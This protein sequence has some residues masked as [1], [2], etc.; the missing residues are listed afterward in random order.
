MQQQQQ[1]NYDILEIII[2]IGNSQMTFNYGM[3]HIPQD[4]EKPF[5]QTPNEKNMPFLERFRPYSTSTL[6]VLS[7]SKVVEFFFDRTTFQRPI[8]YE[9]AN[10]IDPNDDSILRQNVYLTLF[11][12]FPTGFPTTRNIQFSCDIIS[13]SRSYQGVGSGFYGFD[14]Y[15]NSLLSIPLLTQREQDISKNKKQNKP[16]GEPKPEETKIKVNPLINMFRPTDKRFSYIKN[17]STIYTISQVVWRNDIYNHPLYA[18]FLN[19]VYNY[20]IRFQNLI[21]EKLIEKNKEESGQ[22]FYNQLL[23]IRTQLKT[24]EAEKNTPNARGNTSGTK[25]NINKSFPKLS[26][27]FSYFGISLDDTAQQLKW[28]DEAVQKKVKDNEDNI[29]ELYARDINNELSSLY[30]LMNRVNSGGEKEKE[31][32]NQYY[33]NY[34]LTLDLE[35]AST[36]YKMVPW[37]NKNNYY[38]EAMKKGNFKFINDMKENYE[39]LKSSLKGLSTN[40][41]LNK[42]LIDYYYGDNNKLGKCAIF[43]RNK[44]FHDRRLDIKKDKLENIINEANKFNTDVKEI[45]TGIRGDYSEEGTQSSTSTTV[46]NVYTIYLSMNV[47]DQELNNETAYLYKCFLLNNELGRRMENLFTT[48]SNKKS[49]ELIESEI[50]HVP[51]IGNKKLSE[52]AEEKK[53]EDEKADAAEKISE[54]TTPQKAGK[55]TK[56]RRK[57]RGKR[58]TVSFSKVGRVKPK[59]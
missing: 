14:L 59:Q 19:S 26:N 44:L 41:Q 42:S 36:E 55:K 56:R 4:Q 37:K 1:Q 49:K 46:S 43:F 57:R 8:Y 17:G 29:I 20:C 35:K 22:K 34:V 28:S 18:N 7:Y 21:Q 24:V 39:K 30:Y 48:A 27:L 58:H 45:Y 31:I 3:L 47:F 38:N 51:T 52:M 5:I 25:I 2:T 23:D 15:K 54:T 13:G 10:M 12:L 11:Y 16:A 6:S 9:N 40:N 32:I 33:A 50:K 53:K